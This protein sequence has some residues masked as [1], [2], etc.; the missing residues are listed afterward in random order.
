MY[1]ESLALLTDLYELTMAYGY[2]KR[3]MA[4][5]EAVFHLSF[6]KK[7]FEGGY[8]LASGLAGV[9]DYLEKWRFDSSDLDYLSSMFEE[10]FLRYLEQ[11]RFACDIDAVQEGDVVFPNEPLIRVQGPLIQAQLI[12]TALLTLTNFS[13]LISTKAARMCFAAGDDEILEFGLRR[14]QGIDGGMTASRAAYIGGCHATS[15][16]LAG[17]LFGIP[18]RGTHAHSW[19]MAFDSEL[20]SFHAYARALPDN[21]VFLVDTYDTLQGVRRAIEVAQ[22]LKSEGHPFLGIRL[23]SGDLYSLSVEARK[24]LDGAGFPEAKI[25]A[26]NE[27]NEHL[28]ADLKRRG[29]KVAVWGVGTN[30]VTGQSQSALDGVYKISAIRKKG[31]KSWKYRLKLSEKMTKI[32][33][34]GILQ[35]RRFSDPQG[36]YIADALYDVHTDLSA[37]CDIVEPNMH[38]AGSSRDLLVPIFR[39]GKLV[40]KM[41]ALND[42]RAYGQHELAKFDPGLK[43]LVG[44]KEYPV[45]LEHSYHTLKERHALSAAC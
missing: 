10:G 43:K 35:V 1:S 39:A 4:E 28:I 22:W 45:G 38:L 6:R 36:K 11:M 7:P 32:S 44:A 33:N 27:L 3:Q 16:T 15:N 12:E 5:D 37:G 19:I 17:K 41:P 30:L 29:A 2:W 34:P 42:I 18:V 21:C 13:T 23:D 26:S 25:Y 8:A 14:A 24:L 31:E 9:I 40:Y 20:E